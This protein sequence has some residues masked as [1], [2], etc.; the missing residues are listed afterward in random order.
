MVDLII[1]GVVIV[2]IIIFGIFIMI[3]NT[4]VTLNNN[5]KKAW[6]NISVLLE[7][8]HDELGKLIDTVRGYKNYEQSVLTQVTS[9]R[10]QWMNAKPDDIKG[11]IDT[12]NQIS[13]ALKSIFATAEN[14]PDLKADNS[15][16]Q[17]QQR[18]SD[19]ETQIAGRREFY[20]DSVNAFNIKIAIIPYN[21]FS[22]ML[23]YTAQPLFQAPA[24]VT[25]DVKVD[26]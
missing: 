22:G 1:A 14:Y 17:L 10:T 15:F 2:L 19:L 18:I 26:L 13:T 20:N 21:F 8:R 3:Y 25:A 5:V 24:D 12:S 6:A 11:K 4:L 16:I 7:Q 23:H 9:L